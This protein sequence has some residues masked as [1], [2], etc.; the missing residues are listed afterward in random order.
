MMEPFVR[1]FVVN[2][3]L[4]IFVSI[5]HVFVIVI[6]CKAR[7]HDIRYFLMKM[8]SIFEASYSLNYLCQCPTA[9]VV[10][11]W[12]NKF[13]CKHIE[14]ISVFYTRLVI[15]NSDVDLYWPVYCCWI[16][17]RI[18]PGSKESEN[19]LCFAVPVYTGCLYNNFIGS[20]NQ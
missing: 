18:P 10:T 5:L 2:T 3:L 17:A 8:L 9:F 19:L 4:S 6:I 16:R 7:L 15:A 11:K 12:S 1:Y 20:F 14:C 13:T